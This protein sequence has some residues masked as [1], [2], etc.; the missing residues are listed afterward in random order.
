MINLTSP[1]QIAL[2]FFGGTIKKTINVPVLNELG[3]PIKFKTGNRR[4]EI[5]TKKE[6][7]EVPY[8]GL[9]LIPH[10]SWLTPAGKVSVNEKVLKVIAKRPDTQAGKIA[11]L[12]LKIRT[13]QKELGTYYEG[14]QKYIHPNGLIHGQIS[15]C[16]YDEYDKKGGGTATGRTSSI[17]P[18]LQNIPRG[19]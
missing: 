5:K 16:G 8:K 7:K 14:F 9:G 10:K 12:L 6:I 2:L 11:G 15:H 1:A 17:K 4:G 13:R 19:E 18:N 3:C